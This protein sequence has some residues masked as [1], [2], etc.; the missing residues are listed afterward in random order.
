VGSTPAGRNPYID[1]YRSQG[2]IVA[3]CQYLE[4][5]TDGEA[6]LTGIRSDSNPTQPTLALS[7]FPRL[8]CLQSNRLPNHDASVKCKS[9]IA[10]TERGYAW[11]LEGVGEA[12]ITDSE[13]IAK[14][15]AL[16]EIRRKA[17]EELSDL[18]NDKG[19]ITASAHHATIALGEG[20]EKRPLRRPGKK[21]E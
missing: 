1:R 21:K 14:I 8:K 19:L 15:E 10:K 4:L 20:E 12:E 11:V 13:T 17:G 9:Y 3:I 18:I 2:L 5:A 6:K 7:F 16:L